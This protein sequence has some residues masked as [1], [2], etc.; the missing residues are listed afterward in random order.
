MNKLAR[1]F[2]IQ[3]EAFKRHRSKGE[4]KVLVQH[5]NVS[6]SGQAIVGNI[7]QQQK[8]RKRRKLA[9]GS[10]SFRRTS[11][12]ADRRRDRAVEPAL[13]LFTSRGAPHPGAPGTTDATPSS[14][15]VFSY[16][17]ALRLTKAAP[18]R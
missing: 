5:V 18:C 4:Q 10:N 15:P 13:V 11:C 3:L 1:T 17:P 16:V 2:T 9:V 8:D 7:H 12:G 14:P 6:E